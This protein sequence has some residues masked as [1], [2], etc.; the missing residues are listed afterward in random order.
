MV[1][2]SDS[3]IGWNHLTSHPGVTLATRPFLKNRD[4]ESPLFINSCWGRENQR[5]YYLIEF[6]L[7]TEDRG[8]GCFYFL[9]ASQRETRAMSSTREHYEVQHTFLFGLLLQGCKE[10]RWPAELV[11]WYSHILRDCI[12]II[13]TKTEEKNKRKNPVSVLQNKRILGVLVR[14]I[15][16][17]VARA[18]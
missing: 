10:S 9:L 8:Y 6:A 13:I 17:R 11:Y 5:A 12:W 14:I 7:P 3:Q 4:W 15:V 2:I 16:S 1:I 18:K